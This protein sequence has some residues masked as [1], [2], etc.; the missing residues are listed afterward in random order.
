MHS[1]SFLLLNSLLVSAE[2]DSGA[3]YCWKFRTR[4]R[5]GGGTNGIK[6]RCVVQWWSFKEREREKRVHHIY[7]LPFCR[8]GQ[9]V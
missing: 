1:L 8:I 7:R 5:A 6:K 2:E 9:F 4:R 3:W